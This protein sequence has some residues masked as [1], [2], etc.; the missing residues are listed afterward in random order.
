M[1]ELVIFNE[2]EKLSNQNN[3]KQENFDRKKSANGS[4]S[5][6]SKSHPLRESNHI[7]KNLSKIFE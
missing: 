1:E 3:Q 6:R 4:Q 2:E 7:I 5:K